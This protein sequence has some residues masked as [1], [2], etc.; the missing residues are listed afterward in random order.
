MAANDTKSVFVI[1]IPDYAYTPYG[2]TANPTQISAELDLYNHINDS[3]STA[4]HV[5]YVYITDISRQGL[6]QP[7]LVAN[8]GLHPSGVQYSKWVERLMTNV[9]LPS[10]LSSTALSEKQPIKSIPNPVKDELK[11]QLDQILTGSV[12]TT[13]TDTNGNLI[14]T[15]EQPKTVQ[16]TQIDLS[17]AIKTLPTGIYVIQLICNGKL[18]YSNRI[19]KE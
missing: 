12:T 7:N 6:T 10:N 1:S 17:S 14:A 18:F 5:N 11:I 3:I 16:L 15:I 8:D 2:Q 19:I 9:V 13:I 4:Y